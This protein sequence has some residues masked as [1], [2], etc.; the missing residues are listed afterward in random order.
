MAF[1]VTQNP[2]LQRV[3][4]LL[5]LLLVAFASAVPAAEFK[6][7]GV[8]IDVP[9]RFEGPASAQ[10]DAQAKA[11][12]FTVRTASSLTPS[13][14]LQVTVYGAATDAKA[15]RPAAISQRYLSQMLEGIERRRTEYRAS[16]PQEIRV[17]GL[18]GSV[19]SWQG[20]AN[21]IG[22]NGKMYCIVTES[23]LLFFHVMGGGSVPNA[24]MAAAIKAVES[25]RKY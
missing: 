8:A 10:S 16:A 12:V 20:K 7:G 18:P 2:H 11:Y 24:D 25:A 22:T 9:S 14:V 1:L 4:W 13:S 3:A 5:G 21:G 6:A 19:V 23:G 15:E 17:A